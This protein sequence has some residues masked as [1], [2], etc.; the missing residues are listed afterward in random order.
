LVDAARATYIDW[1][2]DERRVGDAYA[3]WSVAPG[4]EENLRFGAYGAAL[5]QGEAAAKVYA[6]AIRELV[7][8]RAG[9]RPPAANH[10]DGT[11]PAHPDPHES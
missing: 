3:G 9:H 10:H 11:T 8:G 1:R 5:D 2:D 6:V 4:A 7:R